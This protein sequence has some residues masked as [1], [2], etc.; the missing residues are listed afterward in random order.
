[1]RLSRLQVQWFAKSAVVLSGT[2][3]AQVRILDLKFLQQVREQSYGDGKPNYHL[4]FW[5]GLR[6]EPIDKYHR[7][8]YQCLHIRPAREFNLLVIG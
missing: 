8:G 4:D 3:G 2:K 7:G 1:L 5:N 6:S